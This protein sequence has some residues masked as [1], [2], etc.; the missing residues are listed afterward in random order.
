MTDAEQTKAILN[1]IAEGVRPSK[2][3]ATTRIPLP[4]VIQAITNEVNERRLRRSE[5]L[6]TF[7]KEQV[8]EIRTFFSGWKKRPGAIKPELIHELINF[9]YPEDSH[10]DVEEIRLCLICLDR[11]FNDGQI[12]EMLCEIERTLHTRIKQVLVQKYGASE[13]GWW[14][15]GVNEGVRQECVQRREKDEDFAEDSPY[16]YTT[17]GNLLTI[18]QKQAAL[19]KDRLPL[20]PKG[21]APNMQMVLE[22]LIR[23]SKIRNRVMHP[24]RGVPLDE[25]DFFFA[26]KMLDT[27]EPTKWR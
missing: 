6:S 14:R 13:S 23:L 7:D 15:K 19:F 18:L 26:K 16:S 2:I 27:L 25:E 10:L 1:L 17:L 24:I 3:A 8:D 4:T 12:Y 22:D 21:K 5:V 11:G 20:S 9:A